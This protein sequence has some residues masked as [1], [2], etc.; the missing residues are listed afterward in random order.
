MSDDGRKPKFGE[1]MR[2]IYAAPD[3]P[4]RD[5]LYVRTKVC[6]GRLNPGTYYQLTD[7]RGKFWEFRASDTI[8]LEEK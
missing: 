5:G 2:G 3:N 4:I 6:R 8:F 7:G 1:W